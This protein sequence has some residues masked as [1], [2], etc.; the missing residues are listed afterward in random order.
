MTNRLHLFSS[1]ANSVPLRFDFLLFLEMYQRRYK[2]V[3]STGMNRRFCLSDSFRGIGRFMERRD[4]S[5]ISPS[6]KTIR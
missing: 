2:P 4:L 3:I 1:S 5:S 6:P